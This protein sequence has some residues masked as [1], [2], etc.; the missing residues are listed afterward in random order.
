MDEFD[1]CGE[2]DMPCPAISAEPGATE[3]QHWAQALSTARDD[4]PGE[5]R[6]QRHRALHAVDDQPIDVFE[7]ASDK[8]GQRVER[9]FVDH[10]ALI[11]IR[12]ERHSILLP[13]PVE[14]LSI[15]LTRLNASEHRLTG[16]P[17][18]RRALACRS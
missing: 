8:R 13:V 9:R 17:V 12:H 7:V 14:C 5:L 3:C 4:V 1:G 15:G 6:D 16:R 11:D 10:L 2:R 18:K